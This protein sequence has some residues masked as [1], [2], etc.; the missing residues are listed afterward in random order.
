MCAFPTPLSHR[1]KILVASR[2]YFGHLLM[3]IS[4]H[5]NF[6][7]PC[8]KGMSHLRKR[9]GLHVESA[10]NLA[11]RLYRSNPTVTWQNST[12]Y[13]YSTI[14]SQHKPWAGF[15]QILR[16][17]DFELL[18]SCS[19][20]YPFLYPPTAAG[21]RG[22]APG[23]K[24]P[25]LLAPTTTSTSTSTSTTATTTTTDE[26]SSIS[27]IQ[28]L[29][30]KM[31]K[32]MKYDE[33][34]WNMMKHDNE[35]W[36]RNNTNQYLKLPMASSR[37]RAWLEKAPWVETEPGLRMPLPAADPVCLGVTLIALWQ[38]TS[39]YIIN[40]YTT[41]F[42]IIYHTITQ[43]FSGIAPPSS[44]SAPQRGASGCAS[45]R[46]QVQTRQ[47]EEEHLAQN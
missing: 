20:M 33:T 32:R 39:I 34:W 36:I 30:L 31:R 23:K 7:C 42:T 6:F 43:V 1:P 11:R 22:M 45:E 5:E 26:N 46:P 3:R 41:I 24:M 10:A 14:F 35:T 17:A 15:V 4:S 38:Y 25:L 12:T 19:N 18:T 27:L 2:Q 29:R 21:R 8:N 40:N 28:T 16:D 44:T 13:P 37:P 9:Q 47:R